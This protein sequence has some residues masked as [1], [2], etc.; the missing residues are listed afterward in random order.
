MRWTEAGLALAIA[1]LTSGFGQIARPAPPQPPRAPS[2]LTPSTPSPAA[3][4]FVVVLDAA[5]GGSDDG[6]RLGKGVLEKNLTLALAEQLKAMLR[7]Q[8]IAVTM[9]RNIDVDLPTLNRAEIA[10]HA[11]AAACLVLHAT[12]TGSGVHLFTSS[13][14]P[15]P[16][17]EVLPWGSAQAE[18]VTESLKLESELDAALVHAE[19]PVTMGRASVAP[20]DNMA[21]P[22]VAVELA[23]L[24]PGNAT[25][26][27]TITNELYQKTVE[28]AMAVAIG[29]WRTDQTER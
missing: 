6:A 27:R 14:S 20:M 26:G 17:A 7:E 25:K 3:K 4:R 28:G 23:P 29:S 21:C 13:L 19:I 5:H 15:V 10:N 16:R 8:G 11:Q 22:T 12:A 24:A 1:G 18:F 2:P 9:T